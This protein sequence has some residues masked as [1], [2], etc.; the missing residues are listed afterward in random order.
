ME[1]VDQFCDLWKRA[2]RDYERI[3]GDKA[4]KDFRDRVAKELKEISAE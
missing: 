3:G 1:D 4:F 2:G